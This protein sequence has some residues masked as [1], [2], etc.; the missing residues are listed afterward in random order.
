MGIVHS[1]LCPRCVQHKGGRKEHLLAA[2]D[3][4]HMAQMS[5]PTQIPGLQLQLQQP[6]RQHSLLQRL[7]QASADITQVSQSALLKPS[8]VLSNDIAAGTGKVS[9]VWYSLREPFGLLLS[10]W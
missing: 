8:L 6:P 5:M 7:P 4:I 2:A 10:F 9:T 1:S 3:D